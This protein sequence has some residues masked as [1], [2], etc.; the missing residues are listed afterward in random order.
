MNEKKITALYERLSKGDDERSGESISIQ[1]QKKLLEQYAKAHGFKNTAHYT[2]MTY[3]GD[4]STV[5]VTFR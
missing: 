2:A 5:P 3:R 1:N 4:F